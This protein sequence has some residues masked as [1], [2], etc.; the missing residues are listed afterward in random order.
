MIATLATISLILV[1]LIISMG[2]VLHVI[3]KDQK[4]IENKMDKDKLQKNKKDENKELH[5]PRR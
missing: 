5:K 4:Y 1:V 2:Y 3:D